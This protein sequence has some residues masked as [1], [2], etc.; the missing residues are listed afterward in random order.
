M[1]FRNIS[2]SAIIFALTLVLFSCENSLE[3]VNSLAN[4]EKMADVVATNSEIIYSDSAK[5][6]GKIVASQINYFTTQQQ[7]YVEFP[8]GLHVFFYDNQMRVSAEV[9]AKY[10]IYHQMTRL[11]EA[12]NN[13]VVT[14]IKGERLN[15]E[16]L[17]WD[18]G[19]QVIY[20]HKYCRI[21]TPDGNQH[22]GGGM[23]AKEDFTQWRLTG[24]VGTVRVKNAQ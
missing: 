9:T 12:R 3:V 16:Q 23:E 4:P 19:K 7:P 17:F 18:Q 5:V 20:T 14:N 1:K 8:N 10:A 21:S 11:C 22:S 24:A 6:R 2:F 15:T 13:V